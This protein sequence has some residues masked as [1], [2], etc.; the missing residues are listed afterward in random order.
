MNLLLIR[1]GQ[2]SN[3]SLAG[4]PAYLKGRLADPPLTELGQQQALRLANWAVGD[5]FC[6]RITHLYTSLTTR[7]VQTAAPL[8]QALGLN[9]HGLP[10]AYECGGLNSGPD[11]GF[12]P[13]AGRDHASLQVDCPALLWPEELQGR[14]WNGGCEP[15]ESAHFATRA[16]VVNARLRRT[17]READV[18]ALIT[19][20]DFAQYLV[21]E[22]LG[23]PA[24][25]G[26]TLTFR[27]NNTATARIE[28]GV[29][30]AGAEARVL[31]WFNRVGHLTPDLVTL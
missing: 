30:A 12:A 11:G 28:L 6:R 3:N 14:A 27:L 26:G 31:H 1:H 19:H 23:L 17:A 9:V 15:W 8:A 16:A 21:A 10:E 29:D 18:V 25:N 2:S 4:G 7:A 20:H 24:L 13:V 5:G 22:L